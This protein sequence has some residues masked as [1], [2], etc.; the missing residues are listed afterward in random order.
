MDHDKLEIVCISLW[1]K[2]KHLYA[3]NKTWMRL[4]DYDRETYRRAVLHALEIGHRINGV[5]SLTDPYGECFHLVKKDFGNKSWEYHD[6]ET[7]RGPF[8]T[9][10]NALEDAIKRAEEKNKVSSNETVP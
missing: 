6:G 8:E 2:V 5:K 3:K 7:W 1:D 10:Q 4:S 9:P